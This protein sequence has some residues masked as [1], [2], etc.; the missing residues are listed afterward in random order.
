MAFNNSFGI[1]LH[2]QLSGP[3][4]KDDA[5]EEHLIAFF[6]QAEAIFELNKIEDSRTKCL[7]LITWLNFKDFTLLLQHPHVNFFRQTNRIT[8][9]ELKDVMWNFFSEYSRNRGYREQII[10]RALQEN[11]L[12]KFF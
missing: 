12:A 4:W 6:A 2:P 7:I 11:L 5:R 1:Q 3:I 9:S 10:D 8:Y